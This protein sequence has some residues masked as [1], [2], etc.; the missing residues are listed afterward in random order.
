[1]LCLITPAQ[2]GEPGEV[3]VRLCRAAE[4][5]R[6][7]FSSPYSWADNL[8]WLRHYLFGPAGKPVGRMGFLPQTTQLESL[9]P[10]LTIAFLGDV[11][12]PRGRGLRVGEGLREFLGGVDRLVLNLEGVISRDRRAW[13][14][15]RHDPA[16]MTFL[17]SLFPAART[18][19]CC[20][21]NH[22]ADCGWSEFKRSC[23]LL[24][25][26]G[27]TVIGS[28]DRPAT[29]LDGQVRVA[30][31]TAWSNQRADYLARLVQT[32]VAGS[33]AAFSILF[34]H[35][36]HEFHLYPSRRQTRQATRLL[37]RW[38]MIVGHH[39]HCPQ[40][41]TV[42]RGRLVAYSLGD[43][44][45]GTGDRRFDHG[46]ALRVAIGRTPDGARRAGRVDWRFTRQRPFGR[47]DLMIDTARD[48]RL[49]P[50]SASGGMA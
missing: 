39:P 9:S 2:P 31:C 26:R 10:E 1:M 27:F 23:D 11:M 21:N 5:P 20:A 50:G 16:I 7:R 4:K 15:L 19:V 12:P 8:D 14:G 45:F 35:W 29:L 49:F 37:R 46:V 48:C 30:A 18:I 25:G 32:D 28:R 43:L 17:E 34:P 47:N 36:G 24:E 41:V 13:N 38:D 3:G 33:P 22:A 6:R 42:H 44:V 40:P